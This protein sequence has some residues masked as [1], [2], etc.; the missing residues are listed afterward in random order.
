MAMATKAEKF[1]S[2][3]TQVTTGQSWLFLVSGN[4]CQFKL[5][6]IV[7]RHPLCIVVLVIGIKGFVGSD[8][9]SPLSS[10]VMSMST[11]HKKIT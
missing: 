3:V 2:L 4:F 1:H 8:D 6:C 10:L 9:P 11:A 5:Q 7:R